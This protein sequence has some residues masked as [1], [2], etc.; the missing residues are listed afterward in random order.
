MKKLLTILFLVA[1]FA[2]NAQSKK[3]IMALANSRELEMVVFG[4]KDSVKLEKLFSAD[5]VYMHSSG[6]TETKAEAIHGIV[7]NKSVYTEKNISPSAYSVKE[8]DD[9]MVVV[10]TFKAV[11]KK[12]TGVESDL[13]LSIT[14]VWVKEKGNWKLFRRRAQ[15]II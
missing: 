7:N 3:I 15:K 12:E 6:K 2:A 8:Y 4:S 13:N 10:H 9:S 1:A 11:E 14:L 5:L